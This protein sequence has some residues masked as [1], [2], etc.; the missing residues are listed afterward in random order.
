MKRLR[1][2]F[3]SKFRTGVSESTNVQQ[4]QEFQKKT[5]TNKLVEGNDESNEGTKRLHPPVLTENTPIR[6]IW[7]VAYEKLQEEDGELIKNYET[8][9]KN[10]VAVSLVQMPPSKADQRDEMNA[11]LKTKMDEINKNVSSPTF[12]ARAGEF[13]QLFLKVVVSAKDYIGEAASTSPY[14][15]IAWAGVS[16]ILPVSKDQMSLSC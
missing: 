6:E 14:T 16:L 9:L 15:S 7:K 8:R 13:A 3:R 10:N 5:D 4:S 12:V 1:S 11:I 2:R